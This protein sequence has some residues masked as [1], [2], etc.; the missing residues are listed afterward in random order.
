[1]LSLTHP[2]ARA[3]AGCTLQASLLG[4]ARAMWGWSWQRNMPTEAAWNLGRLSC[5]S[6]LQGFIPKVNANISA[7]P[8]LEYIA[9][10]VT[11]TIPPAIPTWCSYL[12]QTTPNIRDPGK[13]EGIYWGGGGYTWKPDSFVSI[14]IA[15]IQPNLKVWSERHTWAPSSSNK[16]FQPGEAMEIKKVKD[17]TIICGQVRVCSASC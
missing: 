6:L 4:R 1:M 7:L 13:G 3:K 11:Q 12:R 5:F 16:I 8:S 15:Q 2:I 17:W 10:A 9:R 14:T